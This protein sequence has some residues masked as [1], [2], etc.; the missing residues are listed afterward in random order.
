MCELSRS[1]L[2]FPKVMVELLATFGAAAKAP[3]YFNVSAPLQK[4]MQ[5]DKKWNCRKRKR[6][7]YKFWSL[8]EKHFWWKKK[9]TILENAIYQM[10]SE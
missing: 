2:L 10:W 4:P 6:E 5:D 8:D 1:N 7:V 9:G 3:V